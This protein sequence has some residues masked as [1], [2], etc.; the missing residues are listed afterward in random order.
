[1][2][3][4]NDVKA[5][6]YPSY[7][8]PLEIARAWLRAGGPQQADAVELLRHLRQEYGHVLA[9]GNELVLALQEDGR[10]GEALT[11]L[12]KLERQFPEVDEETRCRW[13]RRHK[14][15]GDRAWEAGNLVAAEVDYLRALDQYE[16]GYKLRDGHYPG[17]NQAT[18]LLLLAALTRERGNLEQSA[19]YLRRSAAVAEEL[20][21]RRG[22]WPRDFPDDNIWHAATAGEAD[23]LRQRW[24]EAAH[25]Y[26]AALTQP[27]VQP[28][29]RQSIGKQGRRILDA[30]ARLDVRPDET[31]DAD[32]LFGPPP[33]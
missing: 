6:A 25:Q 30:W 15:E 19:E 21:A 7:H 1:M 3:A 14:E 29:H 18:V 31:F 28:F 22:Q 10:P 9:I 11:E 32:G 33:A 2:S 23:L 16:R 20:L 13:G 12:D 26:R 24:A 5:R 27:N 4:L 17:I 8:R